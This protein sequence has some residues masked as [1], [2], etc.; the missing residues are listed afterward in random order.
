[1][2][3]PTDAKRTLASLA[4]TGDAA[5]GERETAPVDY[6]SIIQQATAATDSLERAAAFRADVGLDALETAVERAEAEV[7]ACAEDG[8]AAL[9][10]FRAFEVAAGDGDHFQSGRTTDIGAGGEAGSE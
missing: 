5:D 1:M 7:S 8:R 6:R 2:A 3:D 4:R 10:A 9:E